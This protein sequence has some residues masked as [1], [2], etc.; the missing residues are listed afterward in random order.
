MSKGKEVDFFFYNYID[1]AHTI[2]WKYIV[3][4]HEWRDW[5]GGY[6]V[7]FRAKP[8]YKGLQNVVNETMG[9]SWRIV[10]LKKNIL[11]FFTSIEIINY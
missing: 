4:F 1:F 9:E 10:T 7:V 8:K 3:L 6:A 2:T 11:Y 5:K